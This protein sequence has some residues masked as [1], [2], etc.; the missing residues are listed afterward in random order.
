MCGEWEWGGVGGRGGGGGD[1][2]SLEARGPDGAKAG[3]MSSRSSVRLQSPTLLCWSTA[4]PAHSKTCIL[5]GLYTERL[6][7]RLVFSKASILKDSYTD[8]RVH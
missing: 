1:F 3:A 6:V 5:K 2:L 4:G 8:G 7:Q